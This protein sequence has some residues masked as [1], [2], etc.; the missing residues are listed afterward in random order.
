MTA[1]TAVL[2][3]WVDES[4]N[5]TAFLVERASSFFGTY[6]QIGAA[7]ADATTYED[8]DIEIGTGYYYQVRATTGADTSLYT[9]KAF[10]FTNVVSA[11]QLLQGQE[12]TV[13]PNPTAGTLWLKWPAVLQ[14]EVVLRV[15]DA[16]SV[17]VHHQKL[18]G[19]QLQHQLDLAALPSGLYL[20]ALRNRG[21]VATYRVVKE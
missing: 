10:V 17:Q 6:E 13:F 16:R 2:L 21:S 12:V 1:D 9:N 19:Q 14:G 18:S 8:F 3:Q 20:I 11:E 4:D 7:P 5:E 15:L